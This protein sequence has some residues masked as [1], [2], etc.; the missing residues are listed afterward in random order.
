MTS[1][2]FVYLTLPGERWSES[3]CDPV[4]YDALAG[5]PEKM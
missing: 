3:E 4:R 1:E 5:S 2:V